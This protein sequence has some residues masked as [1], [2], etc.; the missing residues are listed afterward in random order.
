M[1]ENNGDLKEL[2]NY[3]FCIF[4]ITDLLLPFQCH[5]INRHPL[6]SQDNYIL[7]NSE[8]WVWLCVCRGDLSLLVCVWPKEMW[9]I[10]LDKNGM[11]LEKVAGRGSQSGL[12]LTLA[13]KS[14]LLPLLQFLGLKKQTWGRGMCLRG[15]QVSFP[16]F[17]NLWCEGG[18]LQIYFCVI[19]HL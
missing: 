15:F 6:Y 16:S 12:V 2:G 1:I 13:G 17:E 7:A 3:Y 19:W 4:I 8:L 14:F 18:N 11:W 5:A 9:K 10:R